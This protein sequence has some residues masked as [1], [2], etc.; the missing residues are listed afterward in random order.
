MNSCIQTLRTLDA[1]PRDPVD[2]R[3]SIRFLFFTSTFVARSIFSLPFPPSDGAQHRELCP[4]PLQYPR[5]LCRSTVASSQARFRVSHS[6]T[7]LHCEAYH[8]RRVLARFLGPPVPLLFKTFIIE[9]TDALRVDL[10][11]KLVSNTV[12]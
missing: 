12:L 6:E 4:T 5:K 11:F 9:L 1:I 7:P 3:A 10:G 2:I 8:M